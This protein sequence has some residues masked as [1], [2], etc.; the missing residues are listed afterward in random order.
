MTYSTYFEIGGELIE[1]HQ[2]IPARPRAGQ[3]QKDLTKYTG[4]RSA[5]KMIVDV[6]EKKTGIDLKRKYTR[7]RRAKWAI[8][9]AG[10][11]AAADGPLPV[12]DAIA[13]GFLG[14]YAVYEATMLIVE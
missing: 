1:V 3:L 4:S 5:S 10:T 11:L 6:A 2:D 9:T 12:G 13:I 8:T 7:F 14:A